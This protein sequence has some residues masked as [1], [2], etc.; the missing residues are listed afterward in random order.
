MMMLFLFMTIGGC[1]L[2]YLSHRNQQWIQQRLAVLPLRLTGV[3]LALGGA[4]SA[5]GYLPVNAA[6]FAWL[7]LMMLV[8]GLLPFASLLRAEPVERKRGL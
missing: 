5:A 6:M 1:V 3:L 7:V 8:I 2:L 4:F